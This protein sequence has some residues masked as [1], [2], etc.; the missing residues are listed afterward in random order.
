MVERLLCKQEVTGS[1]PVISTT[2]KAASVLSF[3]EIFWSRRE[4]NPPDDEPTDGEEH[5]R[6][7]R[8]ESIDEAG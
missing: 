2:A 7:H 4:E 1:S 6:E 8:Q 3:G 5:H